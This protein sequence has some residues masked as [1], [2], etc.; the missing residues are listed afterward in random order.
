MPPRGFAYE[1]SD[2]FGFMC[3]MY[4]AKQKEHASSVLC[5]MD[6]GHYRDA[7]LIARS[8]CEGLAQI[9]WAAWMRRLDHY[10]GGLLL[11]SATGEQ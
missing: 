7:G 1:E 9:K 5:L 2:H 4:L 3:L 6:D 11:T 10:D 8:M